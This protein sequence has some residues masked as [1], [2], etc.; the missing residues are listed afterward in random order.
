[1]H[2]LPCTASISTFSFPWTSNQYKAAFCSIFTTCTFLPSPAIPSYFNTAKEGSVYV[3]VRYPGFMVHQIR[4]TRSPSTSPSPVG[5]F[6][7][8]GRQTH[9]RLVTVG[10]LSLAVGGGI[11]TLGKLHSLGLRLCTSPFYR[12]SVAL[13]SLTACGGFYTHLAT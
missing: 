12:F 4:G 5:S 11:S 2:Q 6:G 3:R 9:R 1:M 8:A 7:L 13:S 10:S